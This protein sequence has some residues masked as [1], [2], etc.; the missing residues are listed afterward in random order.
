VIPDAVRF[1]AENSLAVAPDPPSE[2]PIE[3]IRSD[4]YCLFLSPA[5]TLNF[6]ERLRIG[7]GEV[8]G[9]VEEVR[10]LL[11]ERGRH[12]AAWTVAA[13]ATPAD[14][15]ARLLGFGMTPYDEDPFEPTFAAMAIVAEPVGPPADGIEVREV[16]SHADVDAFISVEHRTM[17]IGGGDSDAM[18]ASAHKMFE[19]RQ[20]DLVIIRMY[21]ALRDG[22]PVGSARA[23]FLPH[24]VNL[25]GGAVV[26]AARGQGVYRALVKARWD[27]AVERGTPALTVQAG[28]MSRPV[29][30][31]LGFQVVST[32]AMLRDR[33]D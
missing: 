21:I 30:E 5:P 22:V 16:A 9:T 31:R 1:Q 6:L 19:L 23:S 11:R 25:S 13:G 20:R 33:F 14:L 4:R 32:M 7:D 24:G 27:E 17:G 3:L 8:S 15:E 26:L 10:E 12:Q 29:L 28:S 18:R 2:L